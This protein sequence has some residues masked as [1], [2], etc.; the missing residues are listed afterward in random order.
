MA[1]LAA[2]VAR[3]PHDLRLLKSASWYALSRGDLAAAQ[4][5]L[6]QAVTGPAPDWESLAMLSYLTLRHDQPVETA[7]LRAL[8]R[9]LAVTDERMLRCYA[10][11]SS[12][13]GDEA[14]ARAFLAK[15]D[16]IFIQQQNPAIR[17]NYRNMAQAVLS[18]KAALFC[19]QYP[20]RK[21]QH[22]E[23]LVGGLAG[24]RFVDNEALFKQALKQGRYADYF[25]DQYGGDFGHLTPKGNALLARHLAERILQATGL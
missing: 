21:V 8:L 1:V 3:F 4:R 12:S 24:V 19:M 14:Q 20:M 7:T 5:L 22:L 16:E 15:A 11:L 9:R 2:G 13:A 23:R 10:I 18:R 25:I 17:D 6:R